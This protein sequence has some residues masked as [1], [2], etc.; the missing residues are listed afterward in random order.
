MNAGGRNP[1]SRINRRNVTNNPAGVYPS[2]LSWQALRATPALG[3][4]A[5]AQSAFYPAG[6]GPPAVQQSRR[7]RSSRGG[8]RVT[9]RLNEDAKVLF[10]VQ[11]PRKGRRGRHGRCRKPTRKNRRRHRCTRYKSLRGKF[12]IKGHAGKNTFRFTGRLRR[13]KL[14]PGRYVLAARPKVIGKKGKIDRVRFRIKRRP[15]RGHKA[16]H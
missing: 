6:S 7:K 1:R 4:Y 9:F 14:K 15:H 5:L 11:K 8:T 16:H 12:T 13:R 10:R 3:S 2:H